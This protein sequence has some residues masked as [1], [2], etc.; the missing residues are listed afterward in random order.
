MKKYILLLIV[1]FLSFGQCI[2][3]DCDNGFGTYIFA[4]G[5]K[6]TGEFKDGKEHG[7]GAY[8]Y[9]N[10]NI[11]M[12]DIENGSPHGNGIQFLKANTEENSTDSDIKIL[13]NFQR[14][15][16]EGYATY[17]YP[18]GME[19]IVEH[20][21]G[22]MNGKGFIINDNDTMPAVF[23]NGKFVKVPCKYFNYENYACDQLIE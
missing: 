10:G 4:G 17:Y 16:K 13:G 19:V 23:K 12:G 22:A 2:Q 6:Y 7:I 20:K 1:P 9:A 3:G 8:Y 14:G 15:T 11:F 21:N 18:G 5:E